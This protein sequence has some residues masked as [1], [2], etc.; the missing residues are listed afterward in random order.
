[1]SFVVRIRRTAEQDITRAQSWYEQQRRGLG[2]DFHA[3]VDRIIAR[4]ADTP[5]IFATVHRDIRRGV[6]HRFPYLIWYRVIGNIVR[7]FAAT[8]ARQNPAKARSRFQ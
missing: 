5:F 6:L 4:L 3:E 8:D 7:V 1:M 2:A